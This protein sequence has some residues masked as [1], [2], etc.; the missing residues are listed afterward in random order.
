MMNT[1]RTKL[2]MVRDD[3]QSSKTSNKKC[4]VVLH[5]DHIVSIFKADNTCRQFLADYFFINFAKTSPINFAQTL[6][7][8]VCHNLLE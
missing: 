4:P 5:G 1:R 2:S 8:L 6:T 7:I 3:S